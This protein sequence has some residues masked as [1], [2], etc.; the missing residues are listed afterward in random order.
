MLRLGDEKARRLLDLTEANGASVTGLCLDGRH[1]GEGIHGI[2]V[3]KPEYKTEDSWRIEGCQV[4]WFTGDGMRLNRI[5]CYS[6]RHSMLCYNHGDGLSQ[7]GWDGF[8]L[9][10]WFS[11]NGRAGYAA[12]EENAAM[13]MTGES[14]RVEPRGR[15]DLPHGE[16]LQHHRQLL[17]P[18]RRAGD[19]PARDGTE[20]CTCY[21][22]TGNIISRSG[23]PWRELAKEDSA[24][25]RF[26][27][28]RGV[29]F[30]SNSMNVGRDDSNKGE[31]VAALRN[32]LRAPGELR[33]QGQRA[34][35]LARW[36]SCWWTWAAHGEGVIVKDNPGSLG[37]PW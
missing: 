37:T 19:R 33:H 28:C 9:D 16:Q 5:W 26:E 2:L 11:G 23:A 3:D 29:V 32:R 34:A 8:L 25:V 12:R 14:R 35:P 31:L 17:R 27:R 4:G 20:A 18:L 10:N 1:L 7:R 30:T 21:T 24:E 22:I 6:L 15:A 36:R 13:T